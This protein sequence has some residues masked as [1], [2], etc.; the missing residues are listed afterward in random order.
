MAKKNFI[1][2]LLDRP[3]AFNPAYKRLTGSTNAALFVS[4]CWYWTKITTDPQGWFYKTRAEWMEETG[5]TEDELDGARKISRNLGITEEKLKGV[6]ATLYYRLNKEKLLNLLGFQFPEEQETGFPETPQFPA[7]QESG[8]SVHFNKESETTPLIT[9]ENLEILKKAGLEWMILAGKEIT[10]EVIDNAVLQHNAKNTFEKVFG[11]GTLPWSSNDV[12]TK[13]EK[14]VIKAY[15]ENPGW[16]ADYVFWRNGD[17]KYKAFS[18]RKIRENPQMFIDTG[19]P[20]Y[21]ASKTPQK[22]AQSPAEPKPLVTPFTQNLETW[23]PY[24]RPSFDEIRAK[25]KPNSEP[26]S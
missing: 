9:E 13:F 10:Q 20:E 4:Q 1:D 21:Q 12:W 22:Q 17:G 8:S 3:I 14:L 6:P 18:N 15:K 7:K 16:I 19:Y 11:F 2:N 5:L 26:L 25:K 24:E 23:Q